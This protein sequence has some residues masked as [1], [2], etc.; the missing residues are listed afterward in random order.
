M[1]V[2]LLAAVVSCET[3]DDPIGSPASPDDLSAEAIG[4]TSV[5]ISWRAA[6]GTVAG[7]QIERRTNLQGNF[8]VI[9][10]SVA[11]SSDERISYFDTAVEP[12][13]YYGYRVR[14]MSQFGARSA[15]T[16]IAGTKTPPIPGIRIA[17]S[18]SLPNPGSADPD[19]YI[20]EIRGAM[21]TTSVP[22]AINAERLLAPLASGNY[23]IVL[24]GVANNCAPATAADS[25]KSV[26]VTDQGIH[27]VSDVSFIVSCR[28]PNRASIVVAHQI[29]GD[30]LDANGLTLTLSG[31][32]NAPGTP[33]SERV[34]FQTRTLGGKNGAARFDNLR[35]GNYEAEISDVDA[36]CQLS[37]AAKQTLQAHAL[38]VDTVGFALTCW[39]PL[40]VDTVGR[41]FILRET[42]SAATA[43]PGDKVSLVTS[44]DL[45]AQPAQEVQGAQVTIEFDNSVIRHDSSRTMLAFDITTVTRAQPN[46]LALV[47]ANT[48]GS[49]RSGNISIVRHWFTVIG[50]SGTS[51]RT[52][53]VITEILTPALERINA[54]VRVEDA[55]LTINSAGEL[56]NQGPRAVVT[57]PATGL[58]GTP[59]AFSGAQSTDP[60]GSIV[61]YSWNFGDGATGTGAS[62]THTFASAGTYLVRLLVTDNQG[63]TG[64]RNQLIDIS[65]ATPAPATFPSRIIP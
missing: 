8:V 43:K 21:D 62:V 28:D 56:S 2:A 9:A 36:P 39:K 53:T 17:T 19:G 22:V 23:A 33:D 54:Q 50:A 32:I 3:P 20:A 5:R 47:A 18:T 29:V 41:P 35:L 60:D 51:V 59:V 58:T 14:A 49:G 16:N 30:T 42:W 45:S 65:D 7:Y 61:S 6:S 13:T 37:G 4:M 38:D 34:Y 31:I 48:D 63:A 27:T 26:T 11:A 44:L 12:D 24:R 55:T 40:V 52:G 46:I 10:P 25:V 57:G 64:F 1:A 15:P